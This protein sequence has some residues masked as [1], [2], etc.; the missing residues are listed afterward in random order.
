MRSLVERQICVW[1]ESLLVDGVSVP[2]RGA[3]ARQEFGKRHIFFEVVE[4]LV[5]C[6]DS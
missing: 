4:R 6:R 1:D 2:P 5:S 3:E